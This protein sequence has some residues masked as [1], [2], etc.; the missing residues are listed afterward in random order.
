MKRVIQAVPC[1]TPHGSTGWNVS[2]MM[3]YLTTVL[4]I[5]CSLT[6]SVLAQ[7]TWS[8]ISAG[9]PH[10]NGGGMILM[11]DGTVLCKSFGGGT[12]GYGNIYDR[13]TPA[14]NGSYA[15]GTWSSIAPM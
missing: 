14:S 7:G 10:S 6:A 11:P 3:R 13:L 5:F 8:Q 1:L 12:D 4:V 9:A 15:S 2:S